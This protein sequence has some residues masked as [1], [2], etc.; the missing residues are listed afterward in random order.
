[1][2]Q[3]QVQRPRAHVAD[4]L[5]APPGARKAV[6]A[7]REKLDKGE[8]SAN[9]A[10]RAL[11]LLGGEEEALGPVVPIASAVGVSVASGA[12]IPRLLNIEVTS[13]PQGQSPPVFSICPVQLRGAD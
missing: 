10:A 2:R 8:I 13:V 1:M 5:Q 4:V 3:P 6:D 12:Q 9:V 7:L 11:A